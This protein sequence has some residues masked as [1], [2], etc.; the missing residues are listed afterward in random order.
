MLARIV[1]RRHWWFPLL[2]EPLVAGMRLLAWWH[3][4]DPYAYPVRNSECFGCLRFIKS[5]LEV[6]SPLF[7]FLNGMIGDWFSALRNSRLTPEELA[8]AKRFAKESMKENP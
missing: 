3:R 7:R 6:K 8:E 1:Y 5:E 2:R 4:I